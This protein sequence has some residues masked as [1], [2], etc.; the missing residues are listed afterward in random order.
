MA[1]EFEEV[2]DMSDMVRRCSKI[3]PAEERGRRLGG[4]EGYQSLDSPR[5]LTNINQYQFQ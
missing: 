2:A 4:K 1:A 3:M 5:G